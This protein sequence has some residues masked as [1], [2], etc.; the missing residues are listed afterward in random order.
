MAQSILDDLSEINQALGDMGPG[1]G[2]A[3]P[4]LDRCADGLLNVQ[5][6]TEGELRD[7]LGACLPVLNRLAALLPD[8][9]ADA[10][11]YRSIGAII[12]GDYRSYLAETERFYAA[13]SAEDPG[14]LDWFT[15]DRYFVSIVACLPVLGNWDGR[16]EGKIIRAHQKYAARYFP[17]SAFDLYCKA[18]A[19]KGSDQH[20]LRLLQD[21]LE[22]DPRWAWAWAETGDI[23]YNLKKWDQ[24]LD[25]YRKAMEDERTHTPALFFWAALAADRLKDADAA[26]EYYGRCAELD[27]DYP[28]A[29][30]NLGWALIRQKRHAEAEPYLRY[31]LEHD[32]NKRYAARNLFDV[33]EKLGRTGDLLA[34]VQGYPEHFRT[35]YY[36]ERVA[37][38]SAKDV[39]VDMEELQ[40]LLEK[41]TTNEYAGTITVS[42]EQ[43]GI[44]LYEH[45]KQAVR[46]LDKWKGAGSSGAGSSSCPPAAA[47]R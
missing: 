1:D 41:T 43:S 46:E 2:R 20:R 44:R 35:K 45:Q 17:K 19:S 40:K 9:D 37:K 29:Q 4:Y 23:C 5:A 25:A 33:L 21:V 10:P 24:A 18:W 34:L 36:R 42:Q 15:A 47:K 27:P 38:L 32:E 28:Y 13:K 39:S 30:N 11:F 26:A 12:R 31:A 3:R 6:A 7:V 16:V 22:K 8:G 14:W